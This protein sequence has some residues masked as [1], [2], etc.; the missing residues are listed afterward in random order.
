MESNGQRK[1]P[2]LFDPEDDD[3]PA[4]ET[5]D[6]AFFCG[7]DDEGRSEISHREKMGR[8]GEVCRGGVCWERGTWGYLIR[9]WT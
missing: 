1:D 8:S 3:R 6:L 5:G 4:G 7:S 2:N 9:C